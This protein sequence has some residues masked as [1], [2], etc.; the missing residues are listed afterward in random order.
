MVLSLY[1]GLVALK[2]SMTLFL[3]LAALEMGTM[4]IVGL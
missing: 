4:K 3:D 1:N 2:E